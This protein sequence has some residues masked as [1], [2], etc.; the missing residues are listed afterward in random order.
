MCPIL[1]FFFLTIV[2]V[3]GLRIFVRVPSWESTVMV[4]EPV[5]TTQNLGQTL[6]RPRGVG[7]IVE[8][9]T[10]KLSANPC[11]VHGVSV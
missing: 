3:P 4:G 5:L 1:R 8:E 10:F 2:D 7:V 9:V 11:D 6:P